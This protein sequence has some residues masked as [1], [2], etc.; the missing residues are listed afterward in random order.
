MDRNDVVNICRAVGFHLKVL[1]KGLLRTMAGSLTAGMIGLS[2]YGYTMIPAEDG[3]IAVG[4]FVVASVVLAM[5]GLCMYAQG[6]GKR[7]KVRK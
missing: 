6:K 7:K 4:E 1:W 2:V 3:Y 5:A